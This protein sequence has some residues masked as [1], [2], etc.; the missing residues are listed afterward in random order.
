MMDAVIF[1]PSLTQERDES[2]SADASDKPT[3]IRDGDRFNFADFAWTSNCARQ[4][5]FTR[6]GLSVNDRARSAP[7]VRAAPCCTS[8][9]IGPLAI[10]S[11]GGSAQARPSTSLNFS[12]KSACGL[13][14]KM[15]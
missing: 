7:L 10:E 5:L 2:A 8:I 1:Q 3:F 11:G 12:A 14:G 6:C 13:D 4:V 15:V 9:G